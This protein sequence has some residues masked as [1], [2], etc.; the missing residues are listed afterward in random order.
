MSSTISASEMFS[1][2]LAQAFDDHADFGDL[3]RFGQ[4]HRPH[5]GPAV[6][7]PLD[8]PLVAQIQQRGPHRAAAGMELLAQ[9]CL[10]HAL[11]G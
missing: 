6:L 3:D 8:E 5:A 11:V 9:V 2:A 10:D 7:N 1:A 4:R